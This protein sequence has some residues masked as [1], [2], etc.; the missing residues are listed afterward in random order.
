MHCVLFSHTESTR[1]ILPS[2]KKRNSVP[3]ILWHGFI[4]SYSSIHHPRL[5]PKYQ[6]TLPQ[7]YSPSIIR[8]HSFIHS[9]IFVNSHAYTNWNTHT[10]TQS[11]SRSLIH[12]HVPLFPYFPSPAQLVH[13]FCWPTLNPC[14]LLSRLTHSA[15][16]HSTLV[17]YPRLSPIPL[18]HTQPLSPTLA[19]HPFCWPTLNPCHLLSPLLTHSPQSNLFF[20]L[21]SE[22]W[23]PIRALPSVFPNG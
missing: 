13:P 8:P 7:T 10:H 11:L 4:L 6:L 16:P 18:T 22:P 3:L 20:N 17:T 15:D 14:H 9:P 19:S 12:T 5:T 23:A 1:T 2:L 21:E